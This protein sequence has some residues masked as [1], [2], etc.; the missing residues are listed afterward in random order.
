MADPIFS[1]FLC[2]SFELGVARLDGDAR[3]ES[4]D[5]PA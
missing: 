1:T 4:V 3:R 2:G 5:G